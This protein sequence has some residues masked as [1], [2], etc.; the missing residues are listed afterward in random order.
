VKTMCVS[1][2]TTR[3][4]TANQILTV[5]VICAMMSQI[6]A[7]EFSRE[8]PARSK[9]ILLLNLVHLASVAS[10]TWYKAGRVSLLVRRAISALGRA[11]DQDS[12]ARRERARKCSPLLSKKLAIVEQDRSNASPI[13]AASRAV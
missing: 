5:S 9:P 10:L 13:P 11:A 7:L 6:F 1:N 12:S 2:N 8:R 3:V 4:M